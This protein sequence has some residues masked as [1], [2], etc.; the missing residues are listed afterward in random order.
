MSAE[1]RFGFR[2]DPGND[3]S[4]GKLIADAT[5]D[6]STLVRG[7]IELAK[8]ELK[9]TAINAAAGSVMFVVAGTFA[10]LALIML[11]IALAYGLVALGL[12]EWV[13]FLVVAL[14]LIALGALLGYLGYRKVKKLGPPTTRYGTPRASSSRSNGSVSAFT[15]NRMA[16]SRNVHAPLRT[17]PETESA[18]SADSSRSG[19]C[20]PRRVPWPPAWERLS[21]V[22]GY[23]RGGGPADACGAVGGERAAPAAGG[24]APGRR[25]KTRH[26]AR[27]GRRPGEG[28][29]RGRGPG[30]PEV[31]HMIRG[32]G[33]EKV[34]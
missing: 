8:L 7:E 11:L 2:T 6:L 32:P 17:H 1:Q 12:W 28:S 3:R 5:E 30:R 22:S 34:P 14:L 16:T 26:I 4:V 21:A 33:M 19:A 25:L 18:I 27:A 29:A 9:Q 23:G 15:R 24:V 31:T 13:A 10:F 20:P